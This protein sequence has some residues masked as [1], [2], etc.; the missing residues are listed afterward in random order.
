M[1]L[2]ESMKFLKLVFL[3]AF[4]VPSFAYAQE[5][6][7]DNPVTAKAQVLEIIKQTHDTLPGLDVQGDTQTLSVKIL[8]GVE[9][10][11]I[12]T[13]ENDYI[14]LKKGEV[15]YLT[16]TVDKLESF[17]AYSVAGP[18]RIPAI[19]FFLGLFIAC[20]LFFGGKQGIR[21]FL[22]LLLSFV[23]IM[24]V[25]LPGLIHGYSPVLVSVG[26]ASLI[27]ILGSYITH[28][29]NKTT[30]AA[31]AGMITATIF[32]G[33]LA[34]IAI[35]VTKLTGFSTEEST[36]LNFNTRGHMDFAGLLLGGM[37]IG[38]LGI[39]Y[40]AAIGQAVS[41]EELHQVGPHLPRGVIYK[42]AIR[43]GRE[44]IG[45]LVNTLAIA[46]VGISLPL[47]LLYTYST[48][49]FL[50]TINQEI[51]ATEIIRVLVGGIGII[52]AVPITTYIATLILIKKEK[53][54][55]EVVA[56]EEAAIEKIGHTH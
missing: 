40:D 44:H 34:F 27:I 20:I 52:L 51:F 22:S 16:H 12:V 1:V 46:Y 10:G 26:V 55:P 54:A 17:D 43:I 32:T 29:F 56:H 21:G 38:L 2:L 28:G 39:L 4:L 7:V 42:R 15:F 14:N 35:N 5:L 3:I 24:Y 25:L 18:D 36:Y 50:M 8:D 13:V 6:V 53:G 23:F 30:T 47:L 31:V 37:I 19:T 49:G 45:A 48:D 41:V 33:V 9:A 11:K